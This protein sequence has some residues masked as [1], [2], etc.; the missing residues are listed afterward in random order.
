MP[1]NAFVAY[2]PVDT[3]DFVPT[4]SEADKIA[5]LTQ[6]VDAAATNMRAVATQLKLGGMAA[7]TA[8]LDALAGTYEV[9]VTAELFAD[10]GSQSPIDDRE[11]SFSATGA[12]ARTKTA[13][14]DA[15]GKATGVFVCRKGRDATLV[16]T[17]HNAKLT[18]T[19]RIVWLGPGD[20]TKMAALKEMPHEDVPTY[21]TPVP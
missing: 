16:A 11:V 4:L 6:A 20:V 18:H 7:L 14:T 21:L 12:D 10:Q 19:A 8:P 9:T 15:A 1:T 5:L 13:R 17:F 3:L 2:S